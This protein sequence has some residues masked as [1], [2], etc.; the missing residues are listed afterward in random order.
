VA[1]A[2]FGGAA[3]LIGT[4]WRV[5]TPPI[6]TTSLLSGASETGS[7]DIAAAMCLAHSALRS[8]SVWGWWGVAYRPC[9]PPCVSGAGAACA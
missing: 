8:S 3:G 9:E 1:G 5:G 4:P 6:M 2:P 7:S